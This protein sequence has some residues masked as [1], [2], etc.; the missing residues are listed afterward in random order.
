LRIVVSGATGTIGRALVEA[1]DARGDEVVALARDVAKAR[2]VLGVE[3]VAWTHPKLEPAPREPLERADAVVNLLGEPVAQRWTEEARHEIHSSRLLGTRNLIEG[4]RICDRRPPVLVSQSATGWYGARGDEVVDEGEPAGRDFLAQV[5][6]DWEH[7]AR[8]AEDLG[9]RVVLTR[10]GVVLAR[11]GGALAR[12]LPA[13]RLG[14]GGPV[15]GGCQW[16]PWVEIDDVAGAIVHTIT[17]DAA[18]GP[19]NVV[20]PNPATNAELARALGR[21]LRRPA[22]MPVPGAALRL[23][24]GEMAQVVTTGARVVPRRLQELGYT[25]RQPELE[26]ALRAALG[27]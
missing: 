11:D 9:M 2:R 17:T 4:L 20:A 8:H 22:V 27:R 1:L 15:A 3:A 26:P 24:Y 21:V 13:F 6:V 23:L 5:T 18:S 19:V 12:M 7:E 25:F 10:T 16:V 14:V